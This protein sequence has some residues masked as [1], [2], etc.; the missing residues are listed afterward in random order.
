MVMY[1]WAEMDDICD[2]LKMEDPGV[3]EIITCD[4]KA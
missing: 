2:I 3:T 4:M 1:A